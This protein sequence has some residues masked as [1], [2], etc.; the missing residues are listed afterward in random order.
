MLVSSSPCSCHPTPATGC[1]PLALL[2]GNGVGREGT[3]RPW[4]SGEG[5]WDAP[6]GAGQGGEH[7]GLSLAHGSEQTV[8]GAGDAHRGR[9]V[10]LASGGSE[11][12][13]RGCSQAGH[14][15][16]FLAEIRGHG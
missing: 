15:I 8:L 13:G 9:W 12:P 2:L 10:A 7:K 1:K 3:A 4:G 14:W 16:G 11:G 5:M 6:G